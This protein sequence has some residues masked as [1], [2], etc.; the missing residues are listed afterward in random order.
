[1]DHRPLATASLIRSECFERNGRNPNPEHV[2]CDICWA[3]FAHT[4]N[5]RVKPAT[6][7]WNGRARTLPVIFCDH[8]HSASRHLETLMRTRRCGRDT[9]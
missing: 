8:K 4:A 7:R 1:M 5:R 3:H 6:H 2:C 9:S